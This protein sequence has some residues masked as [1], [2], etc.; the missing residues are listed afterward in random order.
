MIFHDVPVYPLPLVPMSFTHVV[1]E[2]VHIVPVG[3]MIL[4][5]GLFGLNLHLVPLHKLIGKALAVEG[6]TSIHFI[7]QQGRDLRLIAALGM[8]G[9]RNGIVAREILF[10]DK[11][12]R[13]LLLGADGW[14]LSGGFLYRNAGQRVILPFAC[15]RRTDA[16]AMDLPPRW[17]VPTSATHSRAAWFR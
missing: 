17:P 9:G 16:T 7:C 4:Y 11:V 5:F 1:Q 15:L 10:V 2:D 3:I 14:I 12:N 6:N 8:A 13:L